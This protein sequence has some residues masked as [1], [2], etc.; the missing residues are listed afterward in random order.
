MSTVFIYEVV[1][2]FCEML[3]NGKIFLLVDNIQIVIGIWIPFCFISCIPGCSHYNSIDVLH[4]VK[5]PEVIGLQLLMKSVLFRQVLGLWKEID[6][7]K[8]PYLWSTEK[9]GRDLTFF[10]VTIEPSPSCIPGA[11]IPHHLNVIHGL[12]RNEACQKKLEN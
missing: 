1:S 8:K 9:Y 7:C 12:I 6:S 2:I 11:I 3:T 5:G 4:K 10:G